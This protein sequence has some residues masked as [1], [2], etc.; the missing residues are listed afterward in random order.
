MSS[1]QVEQIKGQVII[2]EKFL[3]NAS[4]V[5]T[6]KN[7]D[8]NRAECLRFVKKFCFHS[9][10]IVITKCVFVGERSLKLPDLCAVQVRMRA[11]N[12]GYIM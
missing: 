12:T 2:E 10:K 3:D 6:P 8:P 1:S 4:Q 9:I 11:F 7:K 5:W